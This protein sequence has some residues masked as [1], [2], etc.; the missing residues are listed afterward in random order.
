M[1]TRKWLVSV[2]VLVAVLLSATT[3]SQAPAQT[4]FS[5][6]NFQLQ[7]GFSF[8]PEWSRL[9][10]HSDLV[11]LWSTKVDVDFAFILVN[12]ASI[13][14][15]TA[16]FSEVPFPDDFIAWIQV[17][18]L[19]PTVETQPVMVGGFHGTQIDTNA[20]PECGAKTNWLFLATTGWHCRK[21]E[22]Y[23]FIYLEDVFGNQ[24][25]IMNTGGPSSAEDFQ[26]G[27]EAA[28]PVLDTVVFSKP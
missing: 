4:N 2:V 28:Q 14:D 9:G 8:G 13:A 23:R 25:L 10:D 17:H 24:V 19:F 11:E 7:L 27:V 3:L 12:D 18:G 6:K 21:G 15:P 1:N 22:Y 16:S 20:T 5:S 26:V